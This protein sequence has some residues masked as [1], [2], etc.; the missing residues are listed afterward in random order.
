MSGPFGG[1]GLARR[2]KRIMQ[3]RGR[4]KRAQKRHKKILNDPVLNAKIQANI[5]HL[6]ATNSGPLKPLPGQNQRPKRR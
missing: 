6:I 1:K 4:I 2:V 3:K 5:E